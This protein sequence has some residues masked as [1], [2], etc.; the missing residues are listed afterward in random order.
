HIQ[1]DSLFPLTLHTV[2]FQYFGQ[3][4]EFV[5]RDLLGRRHE[6]L[7]LKTW[8]DGEC[9]LSNVQEKE[10]ENLKFFWNQVGMVLDE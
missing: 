6:E 3:T 5:C 10:G 8:E 1:T 9:C 7:I 2:D 4:A